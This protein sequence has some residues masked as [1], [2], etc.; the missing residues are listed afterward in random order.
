MNTHQNPFKRPLWALLSLSAILCAAPALAE[1]TS[2]SADSNARYQRDAAACRSAP[3]GT[4]K[5]ACLREA[6]AVRESKDRVGMDPDP[7]RFTRNALKRC[8]ALPEPDRRDCVARIQGNGTTSG[9][10]AGGGLLRELTT[11]DEV[12]VPTPPAATGDAAPA[13]K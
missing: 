1:G 8:E 11:R 5:A 10:V 9:S 6:G 3:Q 4:D 7:G 13:A 12:A 2:G